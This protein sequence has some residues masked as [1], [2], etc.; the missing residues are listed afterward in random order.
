MFWYY[1]SGCSEKLYRMLFNPYKATRETQDT[2]ILSRKDILH[3]MIIIISKLIE[4]IPWTLKTIKKKKKNTLTYL[5]QKY[6]DLINNIRW[7]FSE[8]PDQ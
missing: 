6:L 3:M 2:K 4:L 1:W 7:S 8:Q 5:T